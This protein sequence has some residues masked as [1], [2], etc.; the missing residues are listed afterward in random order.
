MIYLFL[1][2]P[3]FINHSLNIKPSYEAGSLGV[4]SQQSMAYF[5]QPMTIIDDRT[6]RVGV[7]NT[8]GTKPKLIVDDSTSATFFS[9]VVS[10]WTETDKQSLFNI[11]DTIF[12]NPGVTDTILTSN[13]ALYSIYQVGTLILGSGTTTGTAYLS[14]STSVITSCTS[15]IF[16]IK[17]SNGNSY[18]LEV[19]VN[20]ATFLLQYPTSAI[21]SVIPPLSVSDLFN[22]NIVQSTANIFATALESSNVSQTALSAVIANTEYSGY[23][24]QSVRFTDS[25]NN[26][27]TVPFN[28][29]YKGQVP[30]TLAINAA[31]ANLLLTSGIGTPAAWAALCPELFV[32]AVYYLIPIWDNT[33]T[34]VDQTVYPSFVALSKLVNAATSV[35]YDIPSSA[36]TSNLGVLTAVYNQ[37]SVAVVPGNNNP[38]GHTS[39]LTEFP[40][41]VA[42]SANEPNFRYMANNTQSFSN[43]LSLALSAAAGNP[44]NAAISQATLNN[45]IFFTFTVGQVEYQVISQASYMAIVG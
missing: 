43:L 35:M 10:G 2:D 7:A 20:D 40:D 8:F 12:F 45:R 42:I 22:S 36:V 37:L 32:T 41:Y 27:T 6:T 17:V 4:I 9:D 16:T 15:V 33:D 23:V 26:Y 39:L 1:A 18:T 5:V 24:S 21:I 34:V 14:A 11:L 19:F 25:N 31:I 13:N 44:P 29:L 38:I 3:V 28:I 30:G